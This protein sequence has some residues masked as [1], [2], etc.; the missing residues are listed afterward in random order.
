MP[1][2]FDLIGIQVD[3]YCCHGDRTTDDPDKPEPF[4]AYYIWMK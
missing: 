1:G 2:A 3:M 4:K